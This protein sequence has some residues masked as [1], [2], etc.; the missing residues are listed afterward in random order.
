[1]SL[2]K[3]FRGCG[4]SFHVECVLPD[5]SVCKICQSPLVTKLKDLGKVANEAVLKQEP[6]AENE[7]EQELDDGEELDGGDEDD[8]DQFESGDVV[9]ERD[10]DELLQQIR[11]WQRVDIPE[12]G[13]TSIHDVSDNR[14]QNYSKTNVQKLLCG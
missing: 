7:E 3:V 14:F 13:V 8:E 9:N 6:I 12:S 4:H 2:W 5:I 1:M 10:V 11:C